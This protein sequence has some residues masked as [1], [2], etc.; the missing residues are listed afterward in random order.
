MTTI[1]GAFE[2]FLSEQERCLKTK[3]FDEYEEII[4]FFKWYLQGFAYV[5]LSR[6]DSKY[7][8]DLYDK[9]KGYCEVFGTEHIRAIEMRS[10]FGDFI[11]RKGSD[12]KTFMATVG[13]VMQNLI[14]WMH[15][16]GYMVDEEYKESECII[17]EFRDEL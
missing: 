17:K 9:G 16:K 11:T 3:T 6:E 2:E 12:T 1:E 8:D 4:S 5:Y 15:E 10:F 14:K 7:Y 13:K